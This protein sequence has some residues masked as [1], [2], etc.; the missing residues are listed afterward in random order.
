MKLLPK[1]ALIGAGIFVAVKLVTANVI[2][3]LNFIVTGVQL[4]FQG[5]TP[6]V[7]IQ[8]AIQNP[9]SSSFTINSIVGNVFLNGQFIGNVSSFQT[10][11]IPPNGQVTLPVNVLLNVAQV[12]ADVIHIID[13][14]A[15]I[16]AMIEIQATANIDNLAFP[17][18]VSYKL[19]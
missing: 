18:D 12:I 5:T 2:N 1:L 15:G 6:Q 4:G 19:I 8:I 3:R 7:T 11:A 17:L 14:S 10:T 13:G 16:Q 9:T